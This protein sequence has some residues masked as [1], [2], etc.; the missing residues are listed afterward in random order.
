LPEDG[1][2]SEIL[3]NTSVDVEFIKKPNCAKNEEGGKW[4]IH[5]RLT[6]S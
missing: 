4:N 2:A 5:Y 1:S 6:W 3:T